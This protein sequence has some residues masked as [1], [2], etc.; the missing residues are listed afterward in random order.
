MS[1]PW[2]HRQEL[3]RRAEDKHLDAA[4]ERLHRRLLNHA[5]GPL[6]ALDYLNTWEFAE[7]SVAARR[8][9]DLVAS[10]LKTKADVEADSRLR[11]RTKWLTDTLSS[12]AYNETKG[13]E[14]ETL[15]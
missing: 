10:R 2:K 4:C 12:E 5:K 14:Q 6:S 3:H 8:H 15:S 1:R 11:A 9:L 13:N 7:L